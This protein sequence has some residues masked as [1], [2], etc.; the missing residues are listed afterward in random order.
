MQV[1][2]N[3]F[4]NES[5]SFQVITWITCHPSTTF[6]ESPER[7]NITIQNS[8]RV[9]NRPKQVSR[10]LDKTFCPRLS[11]VYASLVMITVNWLQ[12]GYNL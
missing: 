10:T 5:A 7:S 2:L 3:L 9:G 1:K 6:P 12:E 4:S 11:V 8:C